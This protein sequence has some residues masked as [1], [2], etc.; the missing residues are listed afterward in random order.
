MI[1][2]RPLARILVPID[3]FEA[4][5]QMTIPDGMVWYSY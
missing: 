1:A 2:E 5:G 3:T 4:N